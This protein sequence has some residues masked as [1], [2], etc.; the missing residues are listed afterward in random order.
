MSEDIELR[1]IGSLAPDGEIVVKD[2]AALT[3]SLQEL[4]TRICREVISTPG[5]GRTKRFMEEVAQLRLRGVEAGST[6]LVFSKGPTDKL[7]VALPE[8]QVADDRFW[9]IVKAIAEDQR[10]DWVTDLI[11]E[12]AGKLVEA[13]HAAAPRAVLRGPARGDVGIDTAHIHAETWTSKRVRTDTVMTAMGRLEKVDLRSH[14]FR[15]RDDVGHAV[16][17]KHVED[18]LSVAPFVGQWVVARGAG[19][20]LS[21]GR[22]VALDHAV[23]EV[24]TDPVA[25]LPEPVGTDLQTILASAPGPDPDGGVDVSDE[26]FDAFLEVLRS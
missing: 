10:P 21:S 19:V 14:E 6:V 12:S 16:D 3:T 13:L 9:E 20:L 8:Q 26:E 7:D 4:M 1:L 23:I 22:L 15:V 2:L 17:L 18:D 24:V 25:S 5:P 11:S